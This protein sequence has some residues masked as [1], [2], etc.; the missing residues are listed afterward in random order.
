MK[1]RKSLTKKRKSSAG[2][3][4]TQDKILSVTLRTMR[5]NADTKIKS[6]KKIK[7][8]TLFSKRPK[9]GSSALKKGNRTSPTR[10][11]P[12]DKSDENLGN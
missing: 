3:A 9:K 4:R 6:P 10:A 11:T 8:F 12:T 1:A 7:N 5:V 2:S